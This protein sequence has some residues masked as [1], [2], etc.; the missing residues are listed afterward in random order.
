MKSDKYEKITL[1]STLDKDNI[2][3]R[4]ENGNYQYYKLTGYDESVE[5]YTLESFTGLPEAIGFQ[6][7]TT[8]QDLIDNFEKLIS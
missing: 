1:H 3:R 2:V 5:R 6:L 7:V 4:I 8:T